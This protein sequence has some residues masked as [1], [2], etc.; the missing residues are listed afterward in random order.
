MTRLK[1]EI[2][3][4]MNIPKSGKGAVTA[5]TVFDAKLRPLCEQGERRILVYT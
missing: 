1:D 4:T 5:E 2:A 3:T